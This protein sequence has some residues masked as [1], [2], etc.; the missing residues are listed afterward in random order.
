[1]FNETMSSRTGA[2]DKPPAGGWPAA[3]CF[4]RSGCPLRGARRQHRAQVGEKIRHESAGLGGKK[5]VRRRGFMVQRGM[6]TKD[7]RAI[8]SAVEQAISICDS[9]GG[10]LD[11]M[12]RKVCEDLHRVRAELRRQLGLSLP[13][14]P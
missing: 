6:N 12:R 5:A 7:Y 3:S 9:Y 8:L 2:T 10:R 4:G 13:E 14:A 11:D 1:M